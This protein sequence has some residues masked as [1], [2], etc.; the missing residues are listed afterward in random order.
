MHAIESND[1][2]RVI[3][4]ITRAHH[5]ARLSFHEKQDI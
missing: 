4:E 3:G 5:H 2:L 1:I